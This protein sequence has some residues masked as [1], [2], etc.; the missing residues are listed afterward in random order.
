L[1][2]AVG[3][4]SVW[5]ATPS[6]EG[7]HEWGDNII[8]TSGQNAA[9]PPGW[10][11]GFAES[12]PAFAYPDPD[13]SSLPMLDNM[14]NIDLLERQQAV[15]WPEFSWESAPGDPASRCFQ[16]FAPDISR[17]GYTNT[18]RVY[19]IICPQQ[20]AC[21]PSL[22]CMNV[23]VSVTGQRGWVDETNRTL[24]ADM[25]V[26]GKIWFS[27]SALQS[28]M[29]KFLWTLF[30][31]NGLPFP[32]D[33]A[34]AIR[35]TTHLDKNPS[36]PIFPVRAGQTSLFESPDF[37]LHPEAW[38]V[39]NVEVQIGPILKTGDEVVDDFNQLVMDAFNL[40]SGNLLA[41]GNL[42][43][44]NVWFT[45][46]ALVDRKEWRDH[47]EKWRASIDADHGSP[48]GP[49]TSARYFD[50]SPFKPAEALI[51]Q[52]VKKIIAYIRK[53]LPHL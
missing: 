23:E 14:A 26:E 3:L 41:P 21:S 37:A 2:R 11:G 15:L 19:S 20:G 6:L 22:G 24:A 40:A 32:A 38:A 13:L 48:D 43:T 10:V 16:M 7:V 45:E 49:G 12:D 36:Q 31:D 34:H 52:E 53:H 5:R 4:S 39:G 50:G 30:A 47:A 51:D 27:P 46:P 18:G 17:I 33:K 44:W 42:L 1:P 25:T 9:V 29:V 8:V 35:V 28:P